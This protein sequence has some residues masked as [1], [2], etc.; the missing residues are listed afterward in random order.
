MVM[1]IIMVDMPMAPRLKPVVGKKKEDD[2]EEVVDVVLVS[3]EECYGVALRLLAL[4]L[5]LPLFGANKIE[6]IILS[7][8]RGFQLKFYA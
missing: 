1:F 8:S 6:S 2:V 3:A 5:V 4:L 7:I